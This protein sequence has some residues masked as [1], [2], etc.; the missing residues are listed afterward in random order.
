M[1]PYSIIEIPPPRAQQH[2]ADA[3]PDVADDDSV[4]LTVVMPCLNERRTVGT[5]VRKAM[6]CLER[7]GVAG[8]VIVADNGSTD[9]SQEL[10]ESLG[11]RVVPVPVRGYGAALAAGIGAAR[12]RYVVMADSDDSYDL[13]NLM[14]FL[15]RLRA[16]DQLVM[17]NRFLGGIEEGAMPPLHRYFGNPGLTFLGRLFFRSRCRDFYCGQR[18]FNRDAIRGLDLQSTGMEFALEMLVKATMTGLRVSEV[19]IKLAKDGRGRPP[20]LRSWRDGWRSLRF[21]LIFSPKWLFFYPGLLLMAIGMIAGAWLLPG[22]RQLFGVNLDVHTLLYCA[23][24]T[25]VGFQL[26]SFA[27]FGKMLAIATGLHPRNPKVERLCN[28]IPLEWGLVSGAALI[29]AG[30]GTTLFAVTRW[31]DKEFGNLDP[32]SVMRLVVPA[33]LCLI[34]G[35]QVFFSSF[36]FSLLQVQCRKLRGS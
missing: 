2:R 17:G 20:H 13:G 26:V 27:V 25:V 8:E 18:G 15:E 36:Y 11:A 10:A 12:G 9:G 34:L 4:E 21:Y 28:R 32:F 30:L 14:P 7:N 5:C 31:A 19:P 22:S 35:C 6:D 23:A 29:L 3:A 16:G 24:A 33:V 1:N